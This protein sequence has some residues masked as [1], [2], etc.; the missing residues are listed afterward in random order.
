M[1]FFT[2]WAD[3]EI[4]IYK[5]IYYHNYNF[6]FFIWIVK[7]IAEISILSHVQHSKTKSDIG[8]LILDSVPL[9]TSKNYLNPSCIYYQ[10][11]M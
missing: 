10:I 9:K 8:F 11:L 7:T 3:F 5:H 4:I 6:K 1:F 2:G